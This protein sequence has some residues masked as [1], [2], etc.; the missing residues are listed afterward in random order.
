M[1]FIFDE[2]SV[3][4][5]FYNVRQV[6]LCDRAWS[7]KSYTIY[8]N[9]LAVRT[10]SSGSTYAFYLAVRLDNE[11]TATQSMDIYARLARSASRTS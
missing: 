7:R 8:G 9:V 3:E 11:R 10:A 6:S 4:L 5:T 1:K 2:L